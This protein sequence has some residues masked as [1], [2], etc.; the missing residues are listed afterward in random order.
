MARSSR[1][2]G[3]N[4]WALFLL[5]LLGI[6]A[7]SFLGYLTRGVDALKWLD[8]GF[9][10]SIGDA[11]TGAVKLNLGALAVSFGVSLKITVGS[12]IGAIGAIFIYKKL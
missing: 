11:G 12:V 6:V 10:F 1:N 5:I 9:Y 8:R 7:G 4:Y 2:V 3:K